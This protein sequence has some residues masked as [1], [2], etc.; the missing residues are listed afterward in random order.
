MA[1]QRLMVHARPLEDED[2]LDDIREDHRVNVTSS[3][4]EGGPVSVARS[5]KEVS[6]PEPRQNKGMVPVGQPWFE[7][8]GKRAMPGVRGFTIL[9]C[10]E[11]KGALRMVQESI[12]TMPARAHNATHGLPLAEDD[13]SHCF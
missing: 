12:D 6:S 5:P 3:L 8:L 4:R 13:Q 10:G 1:A 7:M 2:P 9:G 11:N